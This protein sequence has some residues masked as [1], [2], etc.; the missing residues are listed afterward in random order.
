MKPV[1]VPLEAATLETAYWL[2]SFDF[3]GIDDA[4]LDKLKSI[5][6]AQRKFD[7]LGKATDFS[8][9]TLDEF[10]SHKHYDMESRQTMRCYTRDDWYFDFVPELLNAVR[11]TKGLPPLKI[12][13]L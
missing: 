11:K 6:E 7:H 9:V 1:Y 13:K 12:E 10:R 5:R 8:Q 2:V 4:G 3:I